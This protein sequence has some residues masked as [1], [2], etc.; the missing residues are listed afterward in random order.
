MLPNKSFVLLKVK[1]LNTGVIRYYAEQ[2]N[3]KMVRINKS[4]YE[5]LEIITKR[6]DTIYNTHDNGI[7]RFFKTCHF[8]A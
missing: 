8:K 4:G 1:N 3:G 2:D 7:A 5:Y 6:H